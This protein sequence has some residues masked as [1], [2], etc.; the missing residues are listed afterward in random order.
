MIS[1]PFQPSFTKILYRQSTFQVSSST[2]HRS[3][4]NNVTN[5]TPYDIHSSEQ[6]LPCHMRTKLA[7]LSQ[8]ITTLAKL[9]MYGE[10]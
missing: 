9:P 4:K 8:Q 2:L 7:Q 3:T 6:K 5:T 10:L 1:V